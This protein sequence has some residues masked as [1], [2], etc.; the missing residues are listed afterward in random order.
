MA[1]VKIMAAVLCAYDRPIYQRLVPQHIMADILC[2]PPTVLHH[3][4]KGTISVHLSKTTGHAVAFDELHEM[5]IN[6]L[7]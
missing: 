5:K 3:L 1:A 7:L 2:F 4:K 6:S